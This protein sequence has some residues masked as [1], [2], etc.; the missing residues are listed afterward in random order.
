MSDYIEIT[1]TRTIVEISEES[2]IID[3]HDLIN[4]LIDISEESAIIDVHD[5]TNILIDISE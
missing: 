4:I 3:V 5:L 1:E 2:A